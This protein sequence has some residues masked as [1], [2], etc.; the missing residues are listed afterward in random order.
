MKTSFDGLRKNLTAEFNKLIN[1]IKEQ[2]NYT[3]QPEDTPMSVKIRVMNLKAYIEMLNCCYDDNDP[4]DYN[5]LSDL[6]IAK[7]ELE[8]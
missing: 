4:E 7:L 5:D 3:H 6:S 1:H 2:E 8:E